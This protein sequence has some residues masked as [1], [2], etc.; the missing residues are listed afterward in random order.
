MSLRVSAGSAVDARALQRDWS[1]VLGLLEIELS[2]P[3]FETWLRGTRALRV[4]ASTLVVSAPR[5]FD[6]EWLNTRLATVV[7]R[8]VSGIFTED[9]EVVFVPAGVP[10]DRTALALPGASPAIEHAPPQTRVLAGTVN[11]AFTFTRY[12]RTDGNSVALRACRALIDDPAGRLAPVVLHARPGMGKTHLLHATAQA[13]LAAGWRVACLGG[14]EF[15]TRYTGSVRRQSI[16]EFQAAVR[17]VD[18]LAV[19]DF[20]YLAG[21]KGTMEE[22]TY[23]IEAVT[24]A[25]GAVLAASECDPRGLD[26]PERLA[27]RLAGGVVIG[28]G[29]L[30]AM[31]RMAFVQ[32]LVRERRSSL[33][34][35]CLERLSGLHASSIRVLQGSVFGAL[36][37]ASDGKLDLTR[38]DVE[39]AR[40]ALAASPPPA[41]VEAVAILAAVAERFALPAAEIA[42]R[43]RGPQV[44]E[45]RA[46][47]AALLKDRGRSLAEIARALDGRDRSTVNDLVAK[48][49][50]VIA[51]RPEL[52][53]LSA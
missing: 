9:V 12:L 5:P 10:E 45:A 38:F 19:D 50:A 39:C 51:T 7:R 42:G 29:P 6:C 52:R 22:L 16:E 53:A 4:E 11:P 1:A 3:N 46:V 31:D 44:A 40:V 32:H 25:G 26:L 34:Q 18:L 47:A 35:W 13:A 37:L 49:R 41:G 17:Q 23:T 33:P 14:E 36:A 48:G 28:L 24:N 20:Q 27:S 8:A 2:R 15:T 43:A 30:A 21:R